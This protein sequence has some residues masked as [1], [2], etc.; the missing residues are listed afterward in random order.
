[1]RRNWRRLLVVAPVIL[2]AACATIDRTAAPEDGDVKLPGGVKA[3]WDIGRAYRESTDTR[4]RICINGLWQFK[5]ASADDEPVPPP[6]SGWGYFKVPGPWPRNGGDQTIYAAEAWQEDLPGLDVAWCA[7]EIEIPR[8]WRGRRIGLY[9]EWLNSYARVFVDGSEAGTVIFPGGEADITEACVPGRKHQLAIQVFARRLNRQNTYFVAPE[10]GAGRGRPIGNRGLVGDVFLT[11]SPAAERVTYAKVETSVRRWRLT[12]EAGLDGLAAGKTYRVR[13]RVLDGGREV[14]AAEGEPF[15]SADVENGRVTVSTDW[16]DPKLWDADAPGNV[17]EAAVE[18]V[19][20]DRTLDAYH[21]V[22]FGF[23]EFW[24]D[25]RDFY[26]NGSRV[27]LLAVPIDSAQMGASNACYEGARETMERFRWLGFNAVYTHNYSCNPGSH[28]GFGDLLKAADDVGML[29]CFSL[30]HMNSYDWSGEQPEKASGYERHLEWYV[31]RSQNHPSV[32][33][34][35]QNHNYL[36]YSDDQNPQRLG[37]VRE[38][39]LGDS[40]TATIRRVYERERILRQFDTAHPVYNHAGP[41]RKVDTVNCYLNWVPMQERSEWF[42]RWAKEGQKALFLVEYGEPLYFSYSSIRD[43]WTEWRAPQLHQYFFTEWAAPV[44]GDAAFDLSEFEKARLRWEAGRWRDGRPFLRWDYPMGDAMQSSVPNL[45]GVQA[46]FIAQTWPSFRTLGL[47]GFDIWH[48]TNLCYL[49]QGASTSSVPR[50]TDWDNAQRPGISPD[51]L[52]G[53]SSLPYALATDA[54]DWVPNVRGE[55][56]RRCS[57]RV[58]AY[59]GGKPSRVTGRGHNYLPGQTVEKQIIIVNDSRRPVDCRARWSVSLPDE[60]GATESIRVEPGEVGRAPIRI[61][62]PESVKAGAY[63]IDLEADLGGGEVQKYSFDIHVLP[64]RERPR[65]KGRTAL[66]DPRGETAK[67]LKGLGLTFESIEADADLSPYDVLV[68]GKAAL[69]VEGSAPDL[70]RVREGLNVVVFE[71]TAEALERRLGF[72]VQEFGLRRGF[73]RVPGHPVLDGLTTDNL[74]DWHGEATL[75][76]P[77]MEAGGPHAFTQVQWCGFAVSRAGRAGCY[78]NVSSV[79]IE[80]PA[81][82]DFLPLVDGGFALQYSP[83]MV[84]RDGKGAVIFCQMDVTGRT[85]ED[86]AA[87]RLAANVMKCA[88]SYKPTARRRAVYAGEPAGLDHLKAA[89]A[90][91]AAYDGGPLAADQVF[92]MGPGAGERLAAHVDSISPWLAGGGHALAISVSQQDVVGLPIGV[93]IRDGEH[94]SSRFEPAPAGTLLAGVGCGDLMIRDPRELPLVADGAE[95]MG[96]G[97]LARARGA[98]VVFCQLAPWQFDYEELYNTK[99]AF[100]RSSFVLSRLLANVGVGLETPLLSRFGA[101]LELPPEPPEEVLGRIRIE[102]GADAHFLPEGWK[103]LALTSGQAPDGWTEHGF[104]D[105]AW[106]DINVP[107]T[108]EGQLASLAGFD[109]KFLYRSTVTLPP[110]MA[111]GEATLVLGAI[112]DEDRTYVNGKFV[113][114]IDQQTNPNDYWSAARR[115]PLPAGALQKGENVIAV[116]VTDLRQAG[117]IRGFETTPDIAPLRTQR[118]NMR[119]LDG[120]YLDEPVDDDDPYRYFRW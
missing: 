86:P 79:M 63:R 66:Y 62:L 43:S 67:L 27:H 105:A 116:E 120:L 4:E 15:T 17:Y 41:G 11:S 59:I 37:D 77:A 82:G 50:R 111:E 30:P 52:S 69:T 57:R 20:D 72:R 95:V 102:R 108:W 55:A 94:I 5:P 12:A 16:R 92:V 45:R 42:A 10:A 109:G 87:S 19:A 93:G 84:Y 31:R 23:R 26:L 40:S 1:M 90:D 76:P 47:S 101:P 114:S 6:G 96:D 9:L 89:G 33:M 98:N 68:I 32:I 28:M 106:E 60:S 85:E 3:V 88:A 73:T 22:R 117:G 80:K 118:E 7:R 103:G 91:V 58:L 8:E 54:A 38:F 97:V 13:V 21:P 18:L 46:E 29:L 71:Q 110:E 65:Q 39:D 2:V 113:G 48:A 56:F 81:R 104:D 100:R 99:M 70:S 78:G 115:Y 53:G 25:G 14:L 24:I 112:D 74:R 51:R 119:W 107:G 34:Y 36:G 44:R 35:S 64:S 61:Q 75:V 49:R 83:L